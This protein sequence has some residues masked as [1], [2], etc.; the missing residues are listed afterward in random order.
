MWAAL[1]KVSL[2]LLGLIGLVYGSDF[3]SVFAQDSTQDP[4]QAVAQVWLAPVE[5]ANFPKMT[6]Y[7][8]VRTGEGEFVFGLE[9]EN[10]HIIENGNLIQAD[11]LR[12]LRQGAQF[13]LAVSPGPS[14]TIRDAQGLT[15]YDYLIQALQE[16]V[17]SKSGESLDDL[18]FLSMDGPETTHV[19]E[20]E[21]WMAVV[22]SYQAAGDTSMLGS[23]ILARALEIAADSTARPGMGR[24]ILFITPPPEGDVSLGLQSLAARASQRGVRIYVWMV[25]SSE[26]FDSPAAAQLEDLASQTGGTLFAYSGIESIPSLE[27]YL[28]PLRNTYFL[29][30]SS[31]ITSSG[32][33][34]VRVEVESNGL[35]GASSDQQFEME[36]LAPSVAFISP[37]TQIQRSYPNVSQTEPAEPADLI[38]SSYDVDV[39]IEFP[40]GHV[41]PLV[42]TTLFVDGVSEDVNTAPPFEQFTWDLSEYTSSGT[43]D[44]K[45][46][47][48]DSLGMSSASTDVPVTIMIKE[49][50]V[51]SLA[52]LSD[53]RTLLA[54]MVVVIA[55]AVLTLVLVLGG[56]LRPGMWRT[57]RGRQRQGDTITQP[58]KV[59]TEPSSSQLRRSAWINRLHF[60]QRA[61][62]PNIYALLVH[63]SESGQEDSSLPITISSEGVSFGN[64]PLLVDQVIDD[65]SIEG[66]HARLKREPDGVFRIY[67]AGSIS[68]TW[69]NYTPVS[70]QGVCLEH[71]DLIHFG[72]V[73]FRF[74]LRDAKQV[75][76]PVLKPKEPVQ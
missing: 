48:L 76:K 19:E 63:Q 16:W 66:L 52:T 20:A 56:R 22:K 37:P 73:G 26:V 43:H 17:T 50:T 55:G 14:F 44:L 35:A 57:A 69:V 29:A 18:S 9:A 70:Q 72:R 31:G 40:D 71:G 38:P 8:D 30:Y 67:D 65:P 68:G 4:T 62:P 15:R 61:V 3:S 59:K 34:Q 24:A 27:T 10:V 64:D 2:T 42:S 47:A 36:V 74:Q 25:A 21:R 53:N 39:L 41:R 58:V 32:V 45:V 75:R 7:L 6:S 1:R 51:S 46:E 49:Q 33:N 54:G 28:E 13:V 5:T 11:E 12:L 60:P 23:D